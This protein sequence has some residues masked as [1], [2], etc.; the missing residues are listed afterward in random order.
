MGGESAVR[1]RKMNVND[2]DSVLAIDEKI[3]GKPHEAQWESRIIDHLS[4]D[5]LGCLVAEV[6]GKIV[7]FVIGN[8]RG[9]EFGIPK[10]GWVEIVGVDPEYRGRGIARALIESL[11]D[12][13]KMNG[14]SKVKTM[15][16]WND[17]GLVSFF[18]ALGFKR[19]EYIILEKE[20]EDQEHRR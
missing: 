1:I 14:V 3:T 8:I 9:W 10:C 12:Y 11:R 4:T 2:I 15:I 13:F 20:L 17:G 16:D 7:G 5:P 6:D 19:S 18:S